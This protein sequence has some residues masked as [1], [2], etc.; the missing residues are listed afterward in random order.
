MK[1]L[2]D[3]HTFIWTASEPKKLSRKAAAAISNTDNELFLSIASVWEMQI[4]SQLRKLTF[5]VPLETLIEM[6]VKE[7]D[8]KLLSVAPKHIFVLPQ[9]HMYHKDPFDILLIAQ[10][11]HE[12]L[13]VL[14]DDRLFGKYPVQTI[15]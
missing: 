9:L 15:W 14:T 10:A 7:N 5:S 11:I 2:L 6:Q 4:K 13:A 12:N 8:L 3:T 1:L